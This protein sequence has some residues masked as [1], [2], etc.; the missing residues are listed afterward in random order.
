MLNLNV[1]PEALQTLLDLPEANLLNL[2]ARLD[3]LGRQQR[4]EYQLANPIDQP[5]GFV[6]IYNGKL[7][8]VRAERGKSYITLTRQT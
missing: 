7:F 1:A 3:E 5:A 4:I 6:Y 2:H 8:S